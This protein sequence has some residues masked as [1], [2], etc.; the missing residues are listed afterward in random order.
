MMKDCRN[1]VNA[2]AT[3]CIS[4][5]SL[6]YIESYDIHQVTV[7]PRLRGGTEKNW[8]L[9]AKKVKSLV[10]ATKASSSRQ[11]GCIRSSV[12]TTRHFRYQDCLTR[13]VP[14]CWTFKIITLVYRAVMPLKAIIILFIHVCLYFK[15]RQPAET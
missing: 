12:A 10:V 14:V 8:R 3:S 11:Q 1:P 15:K 9:L 4:L 6:L 7:H 13:R 2:S 5:D